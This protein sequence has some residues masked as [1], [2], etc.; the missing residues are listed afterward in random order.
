MS[1][2]SREKR[3]VFEEGFYEFLNN[4]HIFS[5]DTTGLVCL[6]RNLYDGQRRF[7]TSVFDGLEEDKHDIYCLKSRQLGISTGVRALDVFWNGVHDGL[8]GAVVFDTDANKNTARREITQML[9][10]L[11]KTFKFPRIR[12]ENRNEIILENE[13]RLLFMAAGTKESRSG[14][15]LGRSTGLA[16]AHCSEIC[17]WENTEGITSFEQ[18]LSEVNPD[19]LYIWESTGRGYNIWHGKVQDAKA[20]ETHKSFVF[21]GWWSKNN[22]MIPAD[23]V[24]YQ[25]YGTEPPNKQEKERIVAVYDRYGHQITPEQLAWVRRKTDPAFED[26][27]GVDYTDD[28]AQ[29]QEQAWTEEDCW[30]HTGSTFFHATTLQEQRSRYVTHKWK[31]YEFL[32]SHATE[33]DQIKVLPANPRSTQLKV[34]EEPVDDA[35]YIIGADPAFGADEKNDRSAIQITRAYADGLDQ[36]AEYAWPL[37]TAENFAWVILALCGWY[38]GSNGRNDVYAQVEVNGP[39][40]AT[41]ATMRRVREQIALGWRSQQ[42]AERGLENVVANVKNYIYTR[43]DS[44]GGGSAWHWKTSPETRIYTLER[45]KDVTTN[46]MLHIRSADLLEEMRAVSRD[47]DKIETTGNR[48]DDRIMSMSF[49]THYWADHIRRTL[50][51]NK[52]TRVEEARK[53]MLTFRDQVGM[54]NDYQITAFFAQKRVV[55]GRNMLGAARQQWRH[56]R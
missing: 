22:Q 4:C 11:P 51:A 8:P 49:C 30:Q 48:K 14:G 41:W 26:E 44:L 54:F 47:G 17:S 24:D 19:R 42:M 6:G 56:G 55:R 29:L 16:F 1:A 37:I 31:G 20:D 10:N 34:W 21:L 25:Q 50:I 3:T 9:K 38:S 35:V 15:G 28:V 27:E 36:V 2:W 45:L 52:R 53:Q 7:F 23:H 32:T 33:F 18:A 13:S 40:A 39:G 46:G 43:M 12:V 5:K